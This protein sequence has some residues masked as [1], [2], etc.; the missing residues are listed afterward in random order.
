M[1]LCYN[2]LMTTRERITSTIMY[3]LHKHDSI[4]PLDIE[5]RYDIQRKLLFLMDEV[6]TQE[7][8]E[9]LTFK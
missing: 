2:R 7:F 1:K 9:G 3:L 4:D 8:G 6:K 5:T